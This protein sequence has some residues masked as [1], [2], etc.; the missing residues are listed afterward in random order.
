[1]AEFGITSQADIDNAI[2]P[3]LA[4]SRFTAENKTVMV[5]N[6][7]VKVVGMKQGDGES[8]RE[9]KYGTITAYDLADRVDM[10]QAQKI[11]DS[12]LTVTPGEVGCQVIIT[13]KTLRIVRDEMWRIIGKLMGDAMGRKKDKDGLSQFSSFGTD[14]GTAGRALTFNYIHAAK[15]AI[16][17]NS[18]PGPGPWNGVFHEHQVHLLSKHLMGLIGQTGT[19]QNGAAGVAAAYIPRGVSEDVIRDGFMMQTI[20]KVNLYMDNNISKDSSDDA[21]GAVFSREALVLVNAMAQTIE[22][23]YDSSLRAWE[24]NNVEEYG[25]GEREDA[26]GRKMTFDAVTPT[27]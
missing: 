9:P 20:N 12:L 23:E 3:M 25:W 6:G 24:V 8:W 16:A 15:S 10:Q 21:I 13:K 14:L 26:W 5:Q 2:K 17:G 22:K 19:G 11:T 1:M 7:I 18:E 27:G 4:E